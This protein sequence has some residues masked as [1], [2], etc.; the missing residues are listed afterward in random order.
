VIARIEPAKRR[1]SRDRPA[2]AMVAQTII[3]LVE[4]GGR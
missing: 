2:R 4:D 1:K 3:S